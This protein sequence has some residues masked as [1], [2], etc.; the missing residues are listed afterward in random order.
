MKRFRCLF[1]RAHR[2]HG[3][4]LDSR[5]RRRLRAGPVTGRA[6]G[7]GRGL[8]HLPA[9]GSLLLRG[10]HVG[11]ASC[12]AGSSL[13]P[14]SALMSHRENRAEAALPVQFFM[15]WV[16]SFID[17]NDINSPSEHSWKCLN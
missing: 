17:N 1:N 9:G 15:N 10:R 16:I 11:G 3:L 4:G 12:G 14:R 13:S 8:G 6:L 5:H 2:M 7:A